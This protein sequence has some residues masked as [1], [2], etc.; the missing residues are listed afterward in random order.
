MGKKLIIAPSARGDLFDI[1]QEIAGDAPGRAVK[2]GDALLDRAQQA[3]D[4]PHSGRV[5][6]EFQRD[7]LR[8]LIHD[9][10]RIIYRVRPE[11]VEVVRFWHAKRGTP[12]S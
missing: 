2:F 8:E 7:D 10:V 12:E 4:C 9:P 5:V 3:A 1:V 11:V 6:P